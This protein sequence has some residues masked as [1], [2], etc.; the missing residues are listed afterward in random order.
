MNF[1]QHTH[2]IFKISEEKASFEFSTFVKPQI[3]VLLCDV[4]FILRRAVLWW[5]L[6]YQ[7]LDTHWRYWSAL[8]RIM[9]IVSEWASEWVSDVRNVKWCG[10]HFKDG[11]GNEDFNGN[12]KDGDVIKKQ[13]PGRCSFKE[14]LCIHS[15][16]L[17]L[18]PG[19]LSVLFNCFL[20][21]IKYFI[22]FY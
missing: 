20:L 9:M 8:M 10:D 14:V 19:G 13:Q 22:A 4:R 18:K 15:T 12:D 21:S 5:I 2:S 6:K 17:I 11:D 16:W 3:I 7:G 1:D